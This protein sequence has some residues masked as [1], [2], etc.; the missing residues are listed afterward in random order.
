[1]GRTRQPEDEVETMAEFL[2]RLGSVPPDRIRMK[3][4]P[5]TATEADLLNA[6]R[7]GPSKLLELVDGV[8][9]EKA[10]GTREALLAGLI[11]HR[12][13]E[14]L[15]DHNLGQ[16]L[17][18]DGMLRLMPGLVRGPDVSFLSWGRVP[19]QADRRRPIWGTGPDLAIEVLSKGNTRGEITRKLRDL[20]FAGCRLAWVINSKTQTAAVYT[21]PDEPQPV[22]ANGVLD[23]ADILPGFRLSLA[24][25]FAKADEEPPT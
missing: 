15:K 4:A 20:F 2:K 10:M 25:L 14:Y 8:L 18:G 13:W 23:A 5:G 6:R 7:S 9:V 21:S 24:D 22:A 1:M 17:P 12:L 19:K 11:L 16:A 3:P